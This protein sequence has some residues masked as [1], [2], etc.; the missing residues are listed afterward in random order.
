VPRQQTSERERMTI[1]P[2]EVRVERAEFADA[3]GFAAIEQ[4]PDTRDYIR[5][6]TTVEHERFLLDPQLVYLRILDGGTPAGFML[7]A[8]DQDDRSVEFRR[9]VVTRRNGGV[10]QAAIVAMERF[11]AQE[12]GRERVWLDVFEHNARARHVYEK[13]G[14][15]P[16]GETEV[17]G[18]RLLLYHKTL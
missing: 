3:A 12:L 5:P 9:I 16:F 13:L 1:H 8:L 10:G 18:S 15:A 17:G 14:Y 2:P 4:A 6:Y 7:L 11:C